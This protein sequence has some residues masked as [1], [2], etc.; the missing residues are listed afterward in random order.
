[1]TERLNIDTKNNNVRTYEAI[2][3]Y[4][5]S[6]NQNLLS[7]D[8]PVWAMVIDDAI[9]NQSY[10][11]NKKGNYFSQ[12]IGR[13]FEQNEKY[14][15]YFNMPITRWAVNMLSTLYNSKTVLPALDK[16]V[17]GEEVNPKEVLTNVKKKEKLMFDK[18]NVIFALNDFQKNRILNDVGFVYL[19]NMSKGKFTIRYSSVNVYDIIYDCNFEEILFRKKQIPKGNSLFEYYRV[20]TNYETGETKTVRR[21]LEAKSFSEIKS[22]EWKNL[23]EETISAY[24]ISPE[25]TI[26]C[27]PIIPLFGNSEKTATL[28]P[29]AIADELL[30]IMFMFAFAGLPSSLMVKWFAKVQNIMVKGGQTKQKLA[31]I[32]DVMDVQE[33]MKDEEI[34]VV[35]TGDGNNFV[36]YM[37]VF[38]A[39]LSW[40]VQ[41]MGV[42][43]TSATSQLRE[44]RQSGASKTVSSKGG[45]IYRSQFVIEFSEFESRLFEATKKW[46]G[47]GVNA[48]L[49]LDVIDKD[50][51]SLLAD[52]GDLQNFLITSVK[53]K[54]T[55]YITALARINGIT[56][57][58]AENLAGEIKEQSEKWQVGQA[59][60]MENKD[61][62]QKNGL[63]NNKNVS[64]MKKG[65]GNTLEDKKGTKVF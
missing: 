64:K 42:S 62:S 39:I 21:T 6:N 51:I 60:Q 48:D 57:E 43:S 26:P 50:N 14:M 58:E 40:L 16:A 32:F 1:M 38:E 24:N 31:S 5:D 59:Q 13:K 19:D 17:K 49:E 25:Q 56:E 35:K 54:F 29:L 33:L 7:I 36:N 63:K 34:G 22:L 45:D 37:V 44:V 11:D 9:Q 10:Y 15:P 2:Q 28:S 65:S 4:G 52:I 47:D 18:Q 55:P 41:L 61:N 46:F 23:D 53:E 8:N 3:G 12:T 30:N 20:D 27:L